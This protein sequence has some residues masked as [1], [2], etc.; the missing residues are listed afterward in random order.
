MKDFT[1]CL[2]SALCVLGVAAQVPDGIPTNDLISWYSFDGTTIDA[3]TFQ[4]HYQA[5]SPEFVTDRFGL[6]DRSI[7]FDGLEDQMIAPDVG[8]YADLTELTL[9][10]WVQFAE[11]PDYASGDGGHALF[12]K[13]Q[14]VGANAVISFNVFTEYDENALRFD[15]R[16]S[17]GTQ[18]NLR[19]EPFSESLDLETWHHLVCRFD[20]TKNQIFWDGALA[21]ESETYPPLPILNTSYDIMTSTEFGNIDLWQGTMDDLG[22]WSRALTDAEIQALFTW[23]PPSGCTDPEACN[24]VA[25]ALLDDGT[26]ASC[27]ALATACGDGTMWDPSTGTCVVA[28]V[29]DVDFDGCVGIGDFL[30][31]LSNFGSGCTPIWVDGDCGNAINYNGYDYET[32]LIGDQCWFAENLRTEQYQNGDVIPA[33]LDGP[34]WSDT[35]EGASSIFGEGGLLV[36]NGNDNPVFNLEATGRLYNWFAVDD[37]RGLCPTGWHVPSDEDWIELELELGMELPEANDVGFRGEGVGSQLKSDGA[38][39]VGWDGTNASGFNGKPGGFRYGGAFNYQ[40]GIGLFWT[41]TPYG[42]DAWYRWM[43]TAN[44]RIQRNN[45]LDPSDGLSV[46]CVRNGE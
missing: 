10:M 37:S 6:P 9:S 8:Q 29:S 35:M 33:G 28:N 40:G 5:D 22:S 2:F 17:D 46:R 23:T 1:C 20:G 16:F 19:F 24:F 7:Q 42:T 13:S 32:V 31:H 26:C 12:M 44:S 18:I 21:A 14:P 41:S 25:E 3:H 30:V 11:Y 36:V 27:E 45:N 38:G 43:E 34:E 4:A 15:T 39:L